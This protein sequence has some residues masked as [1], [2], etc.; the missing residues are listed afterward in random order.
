[1]HMLI[2]VGL[3]LCGISF[4]AATPMAFPQ[5]QATSTRPE[6]WQGP[7]P[8][9]WQGAKPAPQKE[10]ISPGPQGSSP[11]G[12]Q[13]MEIPPHPQGMT[14]P[15]RQQ[16]AIPPRAQPEES[17][18]QQLITVTVTDQEGRYVDDLRPE[19]FIIY[20]D[21][22]PQRLSYFNKGSKEPLSMGILVDTSGSMVGKIDRARFAL[23]RLI[24]SVQPR[25][26]VF[27]GVFNTRPVLLQDFTDSR[28]LL[29]HAVD[30]LRPMG[31]TALYDAILEGIHH[32]KQGRN[33]KK[34]LIVISDGEDLNSLSTLEQAVDTARRSG[35]VVYAIGI[36]AARGGAA[37]G[38]GFSLGPFQ[39]GRGGF[40]QEYMDERTLRE[41][42]EQTGG[43]LSTMSTNDVLANE[44]ALNDALETISRELRLQY[45]LGYTPTRRGSHYR[46]TRVAVRRPDADKLTV[47]TQKG[48]ASDS[49]EQTARRSERRIQQW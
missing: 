38:G 46:N 2:R 23:R 26:E 10:D 28:L 31:G 29:T 32:V 37:A 1:M 47:R 34:T 33:Q 7:W 20:E 9:D 49:Q 39:M 3:L 6:G 35:V 17:R 18:P 42:T 24:A 19:D 5:S 45:S 30:S 21:D 14:E 43:K 44:S 48:Y 22:E 11:S 13:V 16:A 36:G 41:I 40:S 12:K 27:V 15:P 25:D 8:G 4:L